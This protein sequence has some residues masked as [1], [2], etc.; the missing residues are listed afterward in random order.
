M[1]NSQQGNGDHHRVVVATFAGHETA[2]T[3]VRCLIDEDFPMDRISVLGRAEST[4]DDLL[5]VYYDGTS[6]RMKAWATHGVFWGGLWGLLAGAAGMF[7]IPG[8]GAVFAVGPVVEALA[9]AVT[10]AALTGGVMAGAAAI[11]QLAVALHRLGVPEE[12][13]EAFHRAIEQGRYLVILRCADAAEAEH[14]HARLGWCGAQEVE[15]FQYYP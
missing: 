6:A 7:V 1:R 15:T 11:S 14:W 12:R 3:A 5:G 9:G 2:E 13:L 4:G 10:G 8:L